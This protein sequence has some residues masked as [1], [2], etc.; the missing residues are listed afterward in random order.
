MFPFCGRVALFSCFFFFVIEVQVCFGYI[1][2]SGLTRVTRLCVGKDSKNPSIVSDVGRSAVSSRG[3]IGI[4]DTAIPEPGYG[5]VV[6][7]ITASGL[8]GTDI[9]CIDQDWSEKPSSSTPGHEG[10]GRIIAIGEGV[11]NDELKIGTRVGLPWLAKTCGDCSACVTGNE[12]REYIFGREYYAYL[13]LFDNLEPIVYFSH[14][15]PHS[16]SHHPIPHHPVLV[17]I[18]TNYI[19]RIFALTASTVVL[20]FQAA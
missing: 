14:P 3:S 5:E 19:F 15:H 2:R 6:V 18:T 20:R 7:K 13:A 9:H 17:T 4:E 10:V 11:V 8:C 1:P 12:V 16:S